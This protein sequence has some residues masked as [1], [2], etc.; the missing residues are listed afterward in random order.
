[1][2]LLICTGLYPPDIGGPATYSK[3]LFDELPKQGIDV[4]VLSFGE[5]RHLP[6]LIRH[7]SYFLKVLKKAKNFDAIYAQDPVSVGL[8]VCLA[9]FFLRRK[10]TLKV[11]GDYAWE[12]YQ[13]KT[14]NKKQK[15]IFITP[16][17]FQIERYGIL[18]ELRR[19]VERR[20]AKRAEKI[21]VPSKYLKKIV[22]SW[23]TKEEKINVV[24]NSFEIPNNLNHDLSY[25]LNYDF[26]IVTAGRLV[27]WKGVDVLIEIMPK[28]IQEISGAGLVVIGDG[29]KRDDLKK[30]VLK[31]KLQDK[32]LFVGQ[33][34]HNE[35]LESLKRSDVFVLNTGYEGLSHQILEAMAVGTPVITT[36]VGGNP[37]LIENSYSGIL[38]DHNNKEQIVNSVLELY[39][40]KDLREKFINNAKKKVKEFDKNRML[41]QTAKILQ[42]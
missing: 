16:E 14:K 25:D 17:Q 23:G 38:V 40:F 4:S 34:S 37:E 28:I 42:S 21:I 33:L 26:T 6:K 1:M 15:T 36:D 2:R 11:V 39:K 10:F 3:L 27:P 30:Q 31:N 8:P 41:E 20:V 35:V 12:Q 29:P 9:C 18:T 7:F 19:L 5:V 22:S 24:Y 32:V 13:Q